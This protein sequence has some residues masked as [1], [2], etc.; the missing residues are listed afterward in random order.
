MSNLPFF[1]PHKYKRSATIQHEVPTNTPKVW[2]KKNL[3]IEYDSK[4]LRETDT[5]LC[6]SP[7]SKKGLQPNDFEFLRFLGNGK[8]GAVYLTRYLTI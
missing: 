2:V 1:A 5:T 6:S 8:F 7:K 4:D 3:T